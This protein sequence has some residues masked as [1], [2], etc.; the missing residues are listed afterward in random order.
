MTRVAGMSARADGAAAV[1]RPSNAASIRMS[2]RRAD[3]GTTSVTTRRPS[4]RYDGSSRQVS[5]VPVA[6]ATRGRGQA[7]TDV[8]R[9]GGKPAARARGRRN[10]GRVV[11]AVRSAA[12]M[13]R[14]GMGNAC[15]A[16]STRGDW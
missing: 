2:T 12:P 10:V 9:L 15:V 6:A 16:A 14:D 7:V 3:D 11:R 13:G 4:G 1:T 5:L 8:R